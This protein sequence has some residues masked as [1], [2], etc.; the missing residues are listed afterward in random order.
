MRIKGCTKYKVNKNIPINLSNGDL[1]YIIYKAKKGVLERIAIKTHQINSID[2]VQYFDTFNR[3]WFEYELCDE[4]TANDYVDAYNQ[5][6]LGK[7]EAM[8][9][10]PDS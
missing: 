1:L 3:V 10:Q 2:G 5:Y 6:I 8:E 7:I 4:N 9:C